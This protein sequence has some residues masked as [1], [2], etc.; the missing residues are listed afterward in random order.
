M[1]KSKEVREE[2]GREGRRTR[3]EGETQDTLSGSD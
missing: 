1:T 3:Q 2:R